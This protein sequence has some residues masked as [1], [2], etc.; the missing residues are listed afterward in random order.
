[1]E[2]SLENV[3]EYHVDEDVGFALP[4]PLVR[5][6]TEL[7]RKHFLIITYLDKLISILRMWISNL[8]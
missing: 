3:E 8:Y 2:N 4:N 1:M 5:E 7:W 6:G